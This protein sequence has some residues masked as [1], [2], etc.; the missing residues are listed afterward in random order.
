M[1]LRIVF[2]NIV[3]NSGFKVSS[4]IIFLMKPDE[5]PPTLRYL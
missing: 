5:T 2:A 1:K 4:A 3:T